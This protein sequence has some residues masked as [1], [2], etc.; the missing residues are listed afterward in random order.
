MK[1]RFD[2]D[3]IAMLFEIIVI[4]AVLFPI[5]YLSMCAIPAVDD[6][7]NAVVLKGMLNGE[8]GLLAEVFKQLYAYYTRKGGFLFS[9]AITTFIQPY[10][11]GGLT[12]LRLAILLINLVFYYSLWF[13]ASTFLK[14]LYKV[15]DTK[16]LLGF[17]LLLMLSFAVN[18]YDN[19]DVLAWYCVSGAYML[20]LSCMFFGVGMLIKAICQNKVRWMVLACVLSFLTSGGALNVA[21]LNCTVFL[22]IVAVGGV[23]SGKRLFPCFAS[24]FLGAI[25][26]VLAP[27]NFVRHEGITSNYPIIM[28]LKMA[29]GQSMERLQ[30]TICSTPFLIILII[31]FVFALKI[32]KNDV[33]Y[34]YSHPW[35][36]AVAV[37]MG[38]VI[39]NFPVFLG[40]VGYFP[41]RCIWVEDCEIYLG[42][43]A[44]VWYFAGWI[45]RQSWCPELRSDALLCIGICCLLSFG[46]LGEKSLESIIGVNVRIASGKVGEYVSYWEGV[47]NEIQYSEEEDVVIVRED[48]PELEGFYG[49]GLEEDPEYWVN[50]AVAKYYDKDSVTFVIDHDTE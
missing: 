13:L 34:A 10:M 47:L 40:Y 1:N 42:L 8:D 21:A 12:A 18:H 2:K 48:S 17:Y 6:F 39:V 50:K 38:V 32:I 26:N 20:V 19:E 11:W 5:M 22:L 31:I 29:I 23:K 33:D 16:T 27:G 49:V 35:G 43:F 41:E 44:L 25:L 7:S 37:L 28:A 30:F 9:L 45:K 3:T 15:R 14:E 36:L 46:S 24:A 4:I